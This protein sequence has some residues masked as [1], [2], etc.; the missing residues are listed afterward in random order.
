[1]PT[2]LEAIFAAAVEAY[3]VKL[4]EAYSDIEK[5]IMETVEQAQDEDTPAKFRCAFSMTYDMDKN[6]LIYDLSFGVRKHWKDTEEVPDPNQPKLP[7]EVERVRMEEN[8]DDP[9]RRTN[10]RRRS[11]QKH[12]SY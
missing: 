3:R 6:S 9:T 10:P 12:P 7:L 4:N 2:K 8:Q 1:M 5:Q 11:T